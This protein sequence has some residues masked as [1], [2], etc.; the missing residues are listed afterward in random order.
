MSR[1]VVI[2]G[3]GASADFGV[4]TLQYMFKDPHA[5]RY[6]KERADLLSQLNTV[7]WDTRGHGL[8]TSEQSLSIE[9]ML[10][11]LRDWERESSLD[12]GLRPKNLPELRRGLLVLI[13][14]AVFE[15]KTTDRGRHLNPLIEICREKFEHTTWAT[16]NW[17]CMFE[18][19][20]WY[21]Q[22]WMGPGSR[23]NPRLAIPLRNWHGG[24]SK[25]TYLKLHGGINWWLINDE[26]TYLRWTED[27]PLAQK[28]AEYNQDPLMED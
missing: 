13:Q 3:A 4:P 17:D 24:T 7:F 23:S 22:T 16:F 21:S 2:L 28:W 18:S 15:G 27:G 26:I 20:F 6:L 14:K 19:S 8:E 12:E 5:R 10:T 11:I 25:H 9:Q 1:A